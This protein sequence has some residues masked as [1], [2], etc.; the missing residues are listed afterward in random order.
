MP[1]G[2]GEV[3][4]GMIAASGMLRPGRPFPQSSGW[5]QNFRQLIVFINYTSLF[6]EPKGQAYKM[7]SIEV[8][9]AW[10]WGNIL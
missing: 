9:I 6:A 5:R 3:L 7:I 1:E 4:F 8:I 10:K 2:R